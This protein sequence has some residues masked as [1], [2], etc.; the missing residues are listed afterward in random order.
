MA[1]RFGKPF[2]NDARFRPSLRRDCDL[3][4]AERSMDI[5]EIP[6]LEAR[7]ARTNEASGGIAKLRDAAMRP[8]TWMRPPEVS[9]AEPI[10][11]EKRRPGSLPGTGP[12]F[13]AVLR[14]GA[15]DRPDGVQAT[16]AAMAPVM[17]VAMLPATRDFMPSLS[18]SL[19]RDGTSPPSPPSMI[20]SPPKFAKPHMA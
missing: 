8:G 18:T 20:P 10:A 4:V 2:G 16:S 19:R 12:Q 11:G 7:V 3:A 1:V 17:Q 6:A 5:S 15:L 9:G 13:C 14:T